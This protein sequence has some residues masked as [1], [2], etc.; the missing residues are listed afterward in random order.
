LNSG[1]EILYTAESSK[2]GKPV[3]KDALENSKHRGF[4]CK[5]AWSQNLKGVLRE[6]I[7]LEWILQEYPAMHR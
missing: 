4:T 2:P 5:L 1:Y 3:D 7:K 6:I